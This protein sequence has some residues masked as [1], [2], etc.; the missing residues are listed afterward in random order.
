[1]VAP[2]FIAWLGTGIVP[3]VLLAVGGIAHV[4]PDK[5]KFLENKLFGIVT[6]R[7]I[8][9]WASITSAILLTIWK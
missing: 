1:M 9:G 5:L 2:T 8:V 7:A 6:V 3:A 4:I